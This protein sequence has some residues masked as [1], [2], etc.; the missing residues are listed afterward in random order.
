MQDELNCPRLAGFPLTL[1]LALAAATLCA[2]C[3]TAKP[4]ST[5]AP[6]AGAKTPAASS[7]GK[8]APVE[9]PLLLAAGDVIRLTFPGAPE[10]NQSQKIRADGR[11]SLPMV[12]EVGAAGKRPLDLQSELKALFTTQLQNSEV[13]VT[14]EA[15]A[16]PV[17]L[18]GAVMRP[19]RM[20][21]D[22]P[23]N[24]LEVITEAGGFS[25]Q[26]NLRKIRIIRL[27]NGEH[28]SQIVDM[29]PALSGKT[30]KPFYVRP[31]DIIHVGE[32]FLRF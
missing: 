25:P 19:G 27:V 6:S 20:V 30:A 11:I 1:L 31:N 22:R 7:S 14:L 13:V 28:Q 8:K 5:A 15:G 4:K 2:G 23:T 29:K 17:F 9:T 32:N 10:L 3:Q 16:V 26:A 18:S 21:F 24:L 12:G